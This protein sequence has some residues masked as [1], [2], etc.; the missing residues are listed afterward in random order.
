MVTRGIGAAARRIRSA[1]SGAKELAIVFAAFL[2]LLAVPVRSDD[3]SPGTDA[4]KSV[5]VKMAYLGK[6]YAEVEPL[7]LVDRIY[8]D[9]GI[10]GARVG[11]AEDNRT[12]HLIGHNYSLVE[13]IIPVSDD[14]KAKARELLNSGISLIVA[15]LE[16]ADLLAVADLPEAQKAIIF[17]IRSNDVR[18]RNED[19]RKNVFHIPPDWA[20]RA[21]ALGQYLIWKRWRNWALISGEAPADK[22]YA[23]A[24]R[25][26]AKRF[27]GKIVGAVLNKVDLKQLARYGSLGGSEKCFDRYSTYYLEKSEA[28]A[29]QAA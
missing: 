17:S 21:D 26:A 4:T 29:R 5:E 20:M 16:P 8:T 1:L 19:C 28:R 23:D 15:D 9:K 24:V 3:A 22:D 6:T 11:F 13:A 12:G 2:V 25:R 10:Q 7:S 27:G 14:I 18:L